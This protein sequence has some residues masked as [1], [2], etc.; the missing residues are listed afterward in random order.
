[1]SHD[2]EV[3]QFSQRRGLIYVDK[4]WPQYVLIAHELL[5]L[6]GSC[7]KIE[8]ECVVVEVANG[9][10]EYIRDVGDNNEADRF[11]LGRHTYVPIGDCDAA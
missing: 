10:A 7:L 9:R 2:A 4:P 8:N 6:G 5:E 11:V 1:M 3:I